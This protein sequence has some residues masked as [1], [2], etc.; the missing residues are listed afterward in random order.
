MPGLVEAD[1]PAPADVDFTVTSQKLDLNIDFATRTLTGKTDI[2]IQPNHKDLR[3]VRLNCR[4]CTIKSIRVEG[5]NVPLP[6][7]R[8]PYSRACPRSTD[9]V[10]QHHLL[11]AKV[12]PYLGRPPD[13]ELLI[14]FPKGV[15]IKELDASSAPA[16]DILLA[17]LGGADTKN[18]SD[19]SLVDSHAVKIAETQ[20]II[21]TPIKIHVEFSTS[22]LRDGVH[23]VGLQNEDGRFPHA[24]TKLTGFPGTACCVFPCF[25]NHLARCPWE[26]SIRCPRTLGD[27]F[28]K[29][30]A[31]VTNGVNGDSTVTVPHNLV[32]GADGNHQFRGG[33]VAI[34]SDVL[35]TEEEQALDMV[36]VCSGEVT[37]D[38]CRLLR[39][40]V[41]ISD[42]C[43]SLTRTT[44]PERPSRSSAQLQLLLIRS[45]SLSAHLNA[46]IF[47]STVKAD[48][49]RS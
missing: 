3:E 21:F 6:K 14:Q 43:R 9:T 27:V 17:K 1:S 44:H 20:G 4:Q 47:Q 37:D 26:I 46:L 28:K 41:I 39:M 38:V 31:S 24:Y 34:E 48:K 40:K 29:P 15:Q 13:A 49:K 19:L 22:S 11:R 45:V 23:F 7:Y 36:V 30:A 10:F 42:D 12:E 5:R 18:D 8:D 25:D 33:V 35:L 16:Q 2:V 32:N